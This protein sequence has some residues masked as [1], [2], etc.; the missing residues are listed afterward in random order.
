MTQDA[1]LA[2]Q[3]TQLAVPP[4]GRYTPYPDAHA[5]GA[6]LVVTLPIVHVAPLT[7]Q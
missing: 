2:P 4:D 7:P 6:I 3:A 5:V 1:V